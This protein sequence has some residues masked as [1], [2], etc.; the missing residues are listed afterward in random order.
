MNTKGNPLTRFTEKLTNILVPIGEK[1][2]SINSV[3]AI[4]QAMQITLPVMIIGSFAVLIVNINIGPWQDFLAAT[5]QLVDALNK[6]NLFTSGALSLYVLL[7]L[8]YTYGQR[9]DLKETITAIPISTAVFFI[10][11]PLS[12]DGNVLVNTIG[13]ANLFTAL[14]VGLLVPKIMKLMIDR[15]IYIHMPKGI[16]PF[17]EQAFS[18]M[19][20]AILL[21]AIAG[22][23]DV[24]FAATEF[25]SFTDM[26]Y[27]VIQTPLSYF[28]LSWWGFAIV[29][30]LSSAVLWPGLH[31]NTI[32]GVF[33]PL[34]IAS[35]AENQAALQAGQAL[36]N[37]IEMQFTYAC[38]P[39]G[40]ACLLIPC[41]L[42]L[43]MCKSKQIKQI[44][45]VAIIPAI[46][47]IGEPILFGLPCMFNPFLFLPM[48]LSTL[49]NVLFWYASIAI[50]F[51]GRFTGIVLPW[52]TPPFLNTALASTTPIQAVICQAIMLVGCFLIWIPFM[53][54]YDKSLL[55]KEA[56]EIAETDEKQE[57]VSG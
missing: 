40:Q 14:L 28:S 16:P 26:I 21:C 1:L 25:G 32:F 38:D 4:A 17:V 3:M 5:P 27:M 41:V 22:V 20:P 31:A 45:K 15:N 48:V 33:V 46:F 23:M 52:T 42:G 13:T 34:L 55:I 7:I 50:G 36:P 39:G 30:A 10:L 51:V 35:G 47:G 9:L 29:M 56:K 37:I 2:Q 53:R 43:F 8:T 54:M 19:V 18:A 11:A 24:C 57:R 44:C 49:W 6:I 12:E